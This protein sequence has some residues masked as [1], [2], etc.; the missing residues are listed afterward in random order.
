[1]FIFSDSKGCINAITG[2]ARPFKDKEVRAVL[3]EINFIM[4]EICLKHGKS[5]RSVKTFFEFIHVKA[6]TNK[7]DKISL[8][9]QWCDQ[10][11]KRYMRLACKAKN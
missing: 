1:M 11:A 2:E 6:H 10:N 5:I 8:I 3:D 4:M 9:N 7:K